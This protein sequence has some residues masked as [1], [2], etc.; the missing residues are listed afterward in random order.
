MN[1]VSHIHVH[2]RDEIQAHV[3]QAETS[4]PGISISFVAPSGE[5]AHVHLEPNRASELVLL[6]ARRIDEIERL[7]AAHVLG[8]VGAARNGGGS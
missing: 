3:V 7:K 5:Q 8:Q 1:V 4:Q 6:I 2:E